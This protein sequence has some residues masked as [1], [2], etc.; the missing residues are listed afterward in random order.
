MT[1]TLLTFLFVLMA[2]CTFFLAWLVGSVHLA[3]HRNR[4][5]RRDRW[6]R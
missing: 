3:N 2:G 4:A 6:Q 5:G 1:Q